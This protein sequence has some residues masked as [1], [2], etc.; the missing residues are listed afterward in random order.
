MEIDLTALFSAAKAESDICADG[1][2]MLRKT[3]A[4]AVCSVSRSMDVDVAEGSK[5]AV[6]ER[7]SS[8]SSADDQEQHVVLENGFNISESFKRFREDSILKSKIRGFRMDDD[9]HELLQVQS[10]SGIILMNEHQHG[11][12]LIKHIGQ[13]NLDQYLDQ[14]KA[15]YINSDLKV[16]NDIFVRVTSTLRDLG[17]TGRKIAKVKLMSMSLEADEHDSAIVDVLVN[18]LN[19]L[20]EY[21][22][23]TA[24]GEQNLVTNHIDPIVSPIFHQPACGRFFR[25][26]NHEVEN[27]E[28]WRPDGAMFLADQSSTEYAVGFC[29]VK[30]DDND[31]DIGTH[32]DLYRLAIFCKDAMDKHQINA[33]MAFQVVGDTAM[34]Y[35]FVRQPDATY[36]MFEFS[37]LRM[38]MSIEDLAPFAMKMDL[39]KQVSDA[40]QRHCVKCTNISQTLGTKRINTL[41]RDDLKD[42][43]NTGR[44]KSKTAALIFH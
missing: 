42:I 1:Y 25:W 23:R 7:D 18:C 38:P 11:K 31:G 17:L 41:S 6:N 27:T 33:Y 37:R 40:Y 34:F 19:K 10:L 29:E 5:S 2:N 4:T 8:N 26:L 39:L 35:L 15:E 21:G 22:Q 20:P 14:L 44:K 36:A 30:S 9:I 3:T 24:I 43:C 13:R 12:S 16:D 32:E 28:M